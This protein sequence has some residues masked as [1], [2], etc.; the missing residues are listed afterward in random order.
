MPLCSKNF[1]IVFAKSHFIEEGHAVRTVDSRLGTSFHF[2]LMFAIIALFVM[3]FVDD[4]NTI[5]TASL[6]PISSVQTNTTTYGHVNLTIT[7]YAPRTDAF[8]SCSTDIVVDQT[9]GFKCVAKMKEVGKALNLKL[10]VCSVAMDCTTSG[11]VHF[12]GIQQVVFGLPDAFQT[13]EWHVT[14]SFWDPEG[15]PSTWSHVLGPSAPNDGEDPQMLVGELKSPTTLNFGVTRGL[16]E[17]N[18]KNCK[19]AG[20]ELFW[21]G[22]HREESSIDGTSSGKHYVAVR[23]DVG[24]EIYEK[25][26]EDKLSLQNQMAQWFTYAMSVIATMKIAKIVLQ[27]IIDK[28]FVILGETYNQHV[29]ADVQRRINILNETLGDNGGGAFDLRDDD[30]ENGNAGGSRRTGTRTTGGDGEIYGVELTVPV[31]NRKNPLAQHT[32]RV[33]IAELKEQNQQQAGQIQQQAEQNQQQAEQMRVM[34]EQIAKLMKVAVV[35]TK[36]KTATL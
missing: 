1:D 24:E 3:V 21:R 7:T 26:V 25:K 9:N 5:K 12:R 35:A 6:K 32:E 34:Q 15:L 36:S 4:P 27:L 17:D 28:G 19:N 13:I 33:L 29:P 18:K 8:E 20:L 31:M 14:Q 16:R 30:E 23:F 11:D 22:A 10:A 2:V